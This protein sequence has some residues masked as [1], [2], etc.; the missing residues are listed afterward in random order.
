[1]EFTFRKFILLGLRILVIAILFLVIYSFP[2]LKNQESNSDYNSPKITL[3]TFDELNYIIKVDPGCKVTQTILKVSLESYWGTE[4]ADWNES[5]SSTSWGC[6]RRNGTVYPQNITFY[7]PHSDPKPISAFLR[8]NYENA[9][10]EGV[11][12]RRVKFS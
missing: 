3:T 4:I 2:I 1:M 7:L 12:Y 8:I 5:I 9:V 6:G 11:D 10:G